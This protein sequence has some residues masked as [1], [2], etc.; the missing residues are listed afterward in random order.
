MRALVLAARDLHHLF[1]FFLGN[2]M[3]DLALL[4]KMG[5]LVS[6]GIMEYRWGLKAMQT[7]SA[8]KYQ[9]AQVNSIIH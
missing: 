2:I 9:F 6:L 3:A 1:R 5:Y 7:L 8:S 4:L